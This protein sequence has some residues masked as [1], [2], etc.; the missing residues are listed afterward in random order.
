M[1]EL[2]CSIR[3]SVITNAYILSRF[4]ENY[5]FVFL[6]EMAVNSSFILANS[7]RNS[8]GLSQGNY[9]DYRMELIKK[10]VKWKIEEPAATLIQVY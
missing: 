7:I 2:T 1:G 3:G 10:L 6:L 5:N 8:R 9:Y 4:G